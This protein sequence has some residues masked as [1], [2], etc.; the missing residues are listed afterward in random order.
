MSGLRDQLVAS[1]YTLT[2]TPVGQ[3]P[4]F[5]WDERVAAA[6]GAGF[7]GIGMHW[8]DY[9]ALRADGRSDDDLRVVLDEHGLRVVE[10]EFL[11]DWM[12]D[13]DRG[14]ESREMEAKLL[15]MTDVFAPHHLNIG[16]IDMPDAGRPLSVVAERFGEVCDRAADHGTSVALEFLPWSGLPDLATASDVVRA[17]GRSNGGVVLDAWHYFR[18]NPDDALLQAVAA[19][20]VVGVQLDDA[21]AEAVGESY[22]DTVLRRRL[23]GEGS[24]DLVGLIGTIDAA[25]VDVPYSVEIMSTEQQALPVT[26]AAQRAY[27]A[28]AG[29]LASARP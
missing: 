5:T 8:E 4:R 11:W 22:E 6:A 16:D 1:H 15:A 25:G 26:Q 17:A 21:D 24:F 13:G 27:D 20:V 14:R 28:A 23:P 18:G 10:I 9:D 12:L 2:G 19:D 3:P 7:T 29:V